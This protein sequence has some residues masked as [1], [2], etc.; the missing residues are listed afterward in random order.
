MLFAFLVRPHESAQNGLKLP[1]GVNHSVNRCTTPKVMSIKVAVICFKS[2]VLSN[3]EHP[4]MLRITE[5]KK[6]VMKSLGISV[7]PKFWDFKKEEPKAK[8]PNGELIQSII[9]KVKTE[10]QGKILE[11]LSRKEE[12][13]AS[14]LINEQIEEIKAKTVEEF[15]LHLIEELRQKGQIGNSYAYLNSYNTLKNFNKG[16]K[17]NYTFSHI[18]VSF[19]RK[20]EDWM[21]SK[22]NQDTT[23]SYQFRTLRAT[24]N[25][26]IEAKIVSRDKNPFNEYKLSHFNTK[27]MKRALSKEDILKIINTDCSS[28]SKLR[29]LAHDLFSFS[30]LCG[31]ISFVD[32]ANLTQRNIVEGRLIY[33]RQ[34]THGN[35]NLLLSDEALKII[36]KYNKYCQQAGYLFPIL[37]NQRHITPM[38]K[39]N[40]I[41]KICHQVNTDLR[42]FAT[43]LGITAEVTT[44]VARHS[45]ATILKKSGVNIGI[46]SEA[47]G[48]QD[49]KTTQIYLSRF[50]NEQVD[51]AMKN[52]L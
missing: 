16:K 50:D 38:Q 41:H 23:L 7:N 14:S 18:D 24:F 9:L 48:H 44:Y 37:H 6:R 11:K 34:K 3:G 36:Q 1:I 22:G 8:C 13:T 26:A 47:L 2:K 46:I 52:L 19:C 29:Q 51:E 25:K 15:Y 12:F 33:Q 5:N 27:T 21:R 35:I 20:Y 39:S 28:K 40:R 32:I 45:F 4:L 31:G 49:I 43:E 30:Y 17:L 10:Y 42:T